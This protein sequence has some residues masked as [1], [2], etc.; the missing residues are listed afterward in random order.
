MFMPLSF[1]CW[2]TQSIAAIIWETS[3]PPS[4]TPTLRLTIRAG[5]RRRVVQRVHVARR[6]V[7][8]CGVRGCRHKE[9]RAQDR[10]GHDCREPARRTGEVEAPAERDG[11][12]VTVRPAGGRGQIGRGN[13]WTP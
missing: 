2:T 11:H 13:G 10:D 3:V 9:G 8:I 6:V 1:L 5:V 12:L 7:G 4:A